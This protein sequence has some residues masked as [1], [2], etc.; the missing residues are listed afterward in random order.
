M[1]ENT[2]R[3]SSG[4]KMQAVFS[5]LAVLISVGLITRHKEEP[6]ERILVFN[7]A[8]R[9]CCEV[10]SRSA[11]TSVFCDRVGGEGCPLTAVDIMTPTK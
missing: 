1:L 11:T 8:A 7:L 9:D 2:E 5:S 6:R 4:R 10:D 3:S